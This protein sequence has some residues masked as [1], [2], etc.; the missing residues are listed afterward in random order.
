[1]LRMSAAAAGCDRRDPVKCLRLNMVQNICRIC[2]KGPH[3]G[4]AADM[5][6]RKKIIQRRS[7]RDAG[8]SSE[9]S[10][11]YG[12]KQPQYIYVMSRSKNMH[13]WSAAERQKT[14][15]GA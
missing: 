7:E 12:R 6:L 4:A 9:M 8:R 13:E 14:P 11:N 1:M 10:G 15:K 3:A 2:I 5:Y